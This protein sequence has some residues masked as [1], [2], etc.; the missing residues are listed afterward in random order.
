MRAALQEQRGERGGVWRHLRLRHTSGSLSGGHIDPL[1]LARAGAGHYA[2]DG[3]AS[4]GHHPGGQAL[5]LSH[6]RGED[7]APQR[8]KA[9]RA[10]SHGGSAAA[11]V[12]RRGMP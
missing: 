3:S 12:C 9:T 8:G 7:T 5:L 1:T 4:A 11:A 2:M 10:G 6:C